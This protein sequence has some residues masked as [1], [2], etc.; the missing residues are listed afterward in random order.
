MDS[1]HFSCPVE[2]F[3]FLQL[4]HQGY[5]F[6]LTFYQVDGYKVSV[7]LD[8]YEEV[9]L[10]LPEDTCI[11]PVSHEIYD[12]RYPNDC[13]FVGME[14]ECKDYASRNP[15]INYNIVPIPEYGVNE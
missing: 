2:S 5:W 1:R 6:T 4:Y 7:L 14:Q 3:D 13:L 11:F 9:E 15:A 8:F 10:N 12:S